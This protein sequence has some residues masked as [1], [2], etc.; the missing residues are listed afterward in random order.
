MRPRRW[1]YARRDNFRQ[2]LVQRLRLDAIA[3]G[4]AEPDSDREE[5]FLRAL[6]AGRKVRARDYVLPA[7]M[8]RAEQARMKEINALIDRVRAS[9]DDVVMI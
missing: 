3:R 4:E 6:R 9:K 8:F 1:A 2:A 7:L 5:L